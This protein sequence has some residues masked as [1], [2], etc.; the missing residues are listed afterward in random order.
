MI[1]YTFLL[2]QLNS[3]VPP[4]IMNCDFLLNF[5]KLIVS[6]FLLVLTTDNE[7][8]PEEIQSAFCYNRGRDE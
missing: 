8:K 5:L 7:P 3:Y 4:Y 2:R 1:F 6:G